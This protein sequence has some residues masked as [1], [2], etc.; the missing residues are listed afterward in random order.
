MG[1]PIRSGALTSQAGRLPLMNTRLKDGPFAPR[2]LPRFSALIGRSDSRLRTPNGLWFPHQR[3]PRQ[4]GSSCGANALPL[5]SLP[6]HAATRD[7]SAPAFAA[8]S[9]SEPRIG[10]PRLLDRSFGTRSPQPPRN[11]PTG[12]FTP[13]FPVDCRLQ[14]LWETSRPPLSVTRPN[15][16]RFR[17]SS[18][19]RRPRRISPLR[20]RA[21]ARG[22]DCSPGSVALTQKPA[23]TC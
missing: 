10:P 18:R 14:H 9:C 15:R 1:L 8:L 11:G 17:Y 3:C 16:V 6:P 21:H 2:A 12:A 20:P 5:T 22:P 23:A 4:A 19:L 7:H 13:C